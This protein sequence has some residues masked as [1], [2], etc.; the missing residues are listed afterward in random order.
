M[1]QDFTKPKV[2]TDT[3]KLPRVI[4]RAFVPVA[5][6]VPLHAIGEWTAS[7]ICLYK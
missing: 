1:H 5:I 3:A 6:R 2:K 7:Q 4:A